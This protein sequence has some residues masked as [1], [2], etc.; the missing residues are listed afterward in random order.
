MNPLSKMS[1][2]DETVNVNLIRIINL[3]EKLEISKRSAK[4]SAVK[5]ILNARDKWGTRLQKMRIELEV[6][7]ED[8]QELLKMLE[9]KTVLNQSET[10][11]T[12]DFKKQFSVF[13]RE[14]VR[15]RSGGY[16]T[17]TGNGVL[18]KQLLKCYK[19][20]TDVTGLVMM[21][22]KQFKLFCKDAFGD[23]TPKDQFLHLAVFLDEE[24]VKAFDRVVEKTVIE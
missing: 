10:P 12:N 6:I 18:G 4:H 2:V 7:A 5:T 9:E 13:R 19:R 20:W 3:I 21:D 11:V 22:V 24:D 14:R 8:T 17:L 1:V 15:E 16:P 23:P